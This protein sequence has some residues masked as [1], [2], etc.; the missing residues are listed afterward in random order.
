MVEE[1]P[2][3][4]DKLLGEGGD[5][6]AALVDRCRIPGEMINVSKLYWFARCNSVSRVHRKGV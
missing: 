1:L 4:V 5:N 6:I 3:I 2:D